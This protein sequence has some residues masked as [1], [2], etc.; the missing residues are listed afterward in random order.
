[1]KK[2][3]AVVMA[4]MMMSGCLTVQVKTDKVEIQKEINKTLA[5]AGQV[6]NNQGQVLQRTVDVVNSHAAE[7]DNLRKR[8]EM[9]EAVVTLKEGME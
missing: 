6:I 3:M 8:I 7:I 1:M 5:G 9:L 4:A 2:T